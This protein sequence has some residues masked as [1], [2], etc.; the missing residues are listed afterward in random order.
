MPVPL[1]PCPIVQR[2]AEL[3]PGLRDLIVHRAEEGKAKYGQYLSDNPRTERE[4]A[5]HQLQ[6][7]LDALNY[8]LWR[9]QPAEWRVKLLCA[10]ALDLLNAFPDLTLAELTFK[11]GHSGRPA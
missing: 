5:V 3:L 4:K 1:P 9:E 11:E 7:L 2:S 6:E 8:E 10:L